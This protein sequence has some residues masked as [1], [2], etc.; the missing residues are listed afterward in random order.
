MLFLLFE[1]LCVF[2][3]NAAG[4]LGMQETDHACEAVARLLIDQLDSLAERRFEFAGDVVGLEAYVMQTAAA[5]RE[6][7][8]DRVV[9][10]ERLEQFDLAFT[11]PEQCGADALLFNRR[12]FGEMQSERV[13]PESQ[14]GVE[15]RHHDADM[16]NLFQHRRAIDGD[17]GIASVAACPT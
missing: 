14:A 11:Y 17:R 1:R 13:A 12:T 7:L 2:D 3:Q 5:P 10:I 4:G 6:E 15:V 9:G 8:A 16:M